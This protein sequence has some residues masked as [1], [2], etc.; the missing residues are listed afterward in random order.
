M[1]EENITKIFATIYVLRESQ[2]GIIIGEKG[3][4]IK[5]LGTEARKEIEKFLNTKIYLELKVKTLKNWR[6][7]LKWLK[8]LG[9]IQK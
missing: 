8:R 3:K 4:A 1:E 2:K 9:Y 6:N 7:D 5:E